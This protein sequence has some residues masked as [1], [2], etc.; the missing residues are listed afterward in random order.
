M[1][2]SPALRALM[3]KCAHYYT[4]LFLCLLVLCRV[5]G[6]RTKSGNGLTEEV[7][8]TKIY[9]A[10]R[11]HSQLS[12]VLPEL[13]RLKLIS[14]ASVI[15]HHPQTIALQKHFGQKRDFG[16][17]LE[18]EQLDTP[19]SH[20]ATRAVSLGSRKQLCIN[21]QLRGKARDLDEACRELLGG[22]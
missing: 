7:T 20:K 16:S 6:S 17:T 2:I 19:L 22:E 9:Y 3:A 5:E 12:Q 4:S 15:D 18:D 14:K 10:S 1:H 11:T 8:C 13:S 21:D